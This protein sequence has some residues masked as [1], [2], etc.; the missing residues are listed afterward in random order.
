[1]RALTA[2]EG[3]ALALALRAGRLCCQSLAK[4]MG[5][6]TSAHYRRVASASIRSLRDA[7]LLIVSDG[8]D[9]PGAHRLTPPAA[10]SRSD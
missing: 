6:G 3:T 4:T 7:G 8:N 10:R 5:D 1:M 9:F 2:A